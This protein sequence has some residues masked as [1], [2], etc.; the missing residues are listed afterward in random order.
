M[1]EVM[2][3]VTVVCLDN[4]KEQTA[5]ALQSLGIVHVMDVVPP[6]SQDLDALSK[7]QA[8][9]ERIL[10]AVPE[11]LVADGQPR[12]PAQTITEALE[13]LDEQQKLHEELQNISK[14]L[15]LLEPWGSFDAAMLNDFRKRGLNVE[16]CSATPNAIDKLK[17]PEDSLL[18][19]INQDKN[20]AYFIVVSRNS[21]AD[22]NLP[23]AALPTCTDAKALLEQRQKDDVQLDVLQ[24]NFEQ[25]ASQN[26]DAWKK[27]LTRLQDEIALAKAE[28]GMGASGMLAY[29]NGYVPEKKLEMLQKTAQGSG[30]ALRV[31]DISEDDADVPTLLNIPK[32][33]SMAQQIFDFIGILPGY[34]ET[35][36]AVALFIFL[37]LFCGI[38]IG[39]AGYGLLLTV[40]V[41]FG[42]KKASTQNAKDG[43]KLLLSISLS[44]FVYG[45]LS[46]NWFGIDPAI[47]PR[48]MKLLPWLYD[49]ENSTHVKTLC[50]FIGAFHTSFA[51]AWSAYNAQKS[52]RAVF[53][54]LGWSIF[55]WGSFYLAKVLVVDGKGFDALPTPGIALFAIGFVL[56]LACGIN[57]GNVGDVIYSPFTFINGFVDVLS[58]IR[59][60]AVGLSG[61]YIAKC[62]NEMAVG[63]GKSG[64]LGILAMPIV[65]LIGHGLNICMAFLSVLVHGIRLNTLEFA[66][67]IGVSWSG[68]PYKPLA[69]HNS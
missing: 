14:E 57:W 42:F 63:L 7:K 53:G 56:I 45:W 30:W 32:K 13:N 11:T 18:K 55:L 52:K 59:L 4:A 8:D 1:I 22:S 29:L 49:D 47:M 65:L 35:D 50:F 28:C 2:K 25:L 9:L 31:E 23:I 44:V 15:E 33:F 21:L 16:L 62:F 10:K 36:V 67:H 26:A 66:G 38:L 54:H 41:L 60:F 6:A 19:I 64:V 27:E 46:G 58:Y 3:K 39:D 51:R 43:L 37:T 48:C 68:R 61:V 5:K 40:A 12:L 69:I 17:L 34:F 20:N 24:K